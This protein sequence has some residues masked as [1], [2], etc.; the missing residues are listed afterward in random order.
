M[1]I[2]N[3]DGYG[4]GGCRTGY[5]AQLRGANSWGGGEG[6]PEGDG[7]NFPER[8]EFGDYTDTFQ[9]VWGGGSW[10]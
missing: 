1:G 5:D 8:W 9:L 4:D 2:L 10:F 7:I 3:G 6:N